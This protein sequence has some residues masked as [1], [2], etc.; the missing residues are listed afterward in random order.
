MIGI[1]A[2]IVQDDGTLV[3]RFH[4]WRF[5][6]AT[7]ACVE[8]PNAPNPDAAA[9]LCGSARTCGRVF[10]VREEAGLVWI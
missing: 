1:Q 6:G 8:L 9:R 2:G 5:E 7:G 10:P 3:C 4:G